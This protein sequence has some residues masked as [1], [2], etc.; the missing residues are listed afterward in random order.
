M[1]FDIA[2]LAKAETTRVRV[3]FGAN[4]LVYDDVTLHYRG[5][6]VDVSF[7]GWSAKIEGI[8]DKPVEVFIKEACLLI[9]SANYFLYEKAGNLSW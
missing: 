9:P 2:D 1:N 3:R 8:K 5:K 7:L 6:T 4:G